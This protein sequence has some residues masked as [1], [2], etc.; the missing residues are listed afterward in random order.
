MREKVRLL[1]EA[2][3]NIIFNYFEQLEMNGVYKVTGAESYVKKIKTV[4]RASLYSHESEYIA[5][6]EDGIIKALIIL[7]YYIDKTSS[8]Y[9][10]FISFSISKH[11]QSIFE[12]IRYD[13]ENSLFIKSFNK[14]RFMYADKENNNTNW[15]KLLIDFGFELEADKYKENKISLILW[16]DKSGGKDE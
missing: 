9:V 15:K 2:D 5:Y 14:I 6:I 8:Y 1:N 3:T 13:L 12:F 4:L 16:I 7:S 11:L 10:D